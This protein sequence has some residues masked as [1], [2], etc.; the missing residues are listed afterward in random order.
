MNIRVLFSLLA[1][2]SLGLSQSVD[3]KVAEAVAANDRAYEA[4]H[5]KGDAAALAGF[6]AEDAE[7]TSEDG[8]VFTGRAA[9]E[10][11]LKTGLAKAK[12]SRIA[13]ETGVVEKLAD[14]V[15]VQKGSTVV[16]E[17]DGA[18]SRS[19]FTA[20]H[21]KKDGQWKIRHLTETPLPAPGAEARLQELAWL[22]GKW[23]EKDA[24]AGVSVKSEDV[25]WRL[26]ENKET[27]YATRLG[28]LTRDVSPITIH[29]ADG[30]VQTWLLVRLPPPAEAGEAAAIPAVDRQPPPPFALP[31][32]AKPGAPVPPPAPA[33]VP[34]PAVA[35]PPAP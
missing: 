5:A 35:I 6:F 18:A 25:A 34:A 16:T 26:G 21:V 27:V 10:G 1:L 33:A 9:I 15:V 20:I 19:L 17:T 4:A 24:T 28:N 30:Q 29:F 31:V 11:A 22:L 23:E 13:I 3:P 32:A 14:D 7:Y 2:V 8:E 12:G